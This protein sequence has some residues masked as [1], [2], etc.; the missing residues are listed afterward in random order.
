M[1]DDLDEGV[2]DQQASRSARRR[3]RA[4][5]RRR[6][7]RP[8]RA[9]TCR[10]TRRAGGT[11]AAPR[12]RAA[13]GSTRACVERAVA[14]G[15]RHRV[16]RSSSSRAR[17]VRR[18]ARRTGPTR[19]P[20]PARWPAAARRAEADPANALAHPRR[21]RVEPCRASIGPLGEQRDG[22]RVG[23]LGAG[24][25]PWAPHAVAPARPPTRHT[26][27]PGTPSGWR[28][29]AI[30]RSDGERVEEVDDGRA[31]HA[32]TTCSQLS[33]TRSVDSGTPRGR[34]R[35]RDVGARSRGEDRRG[36]AWATQAASS[37]VLDRS[38]HQAPPTKSGRIVSASAAASRVLPAPPGPHRVITRVRQASECSSAR[39]AFRPTSL[40]SWTG[41][42]PCAPSRCSLS[43]VEVSS[44]SQHTSPAVARWPV[45]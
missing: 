8:R 35:R 18:S 22:A 43:W 28:L 37:V 26:C 9:R 15:R 11:A 45:R 44:I 24:R 23:V 3:R 34:A 20:R 25:A 14:L 36:D 31:A 17:A 42:F 21:D 2:V 16:L 32:S 19:G 33:S 29:V 10:G 40:V 12:A 5:S 7:T 41:R 6:R 1:V 39:A 38:T 4:G 30:T 13:G 27:S